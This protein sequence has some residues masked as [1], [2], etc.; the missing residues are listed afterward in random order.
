MAAASIIVRLIGILYRIPLINII[1]DK[2]MGYYSNAFVIYSILLLL[3]SYSLPLAV[4]KMVSA[5]VARGQYKNSVRILRTALA[6]ATLVGGIGAAVTWFGANFFA[7]TFFP[8]PFCVYAIKTLAPTVWIMAYLGVFRGYFQGMGTMIPTAMSQILEQIINA[9]ISVGAAYLLFDYGINSNLVYE[10]TEYSYAFGA[11]GGT[12]GTGAG[13]LAALV[14]MLLLFAVYR[15]VLKKQLRRDRTRKL[16]SYSQIGYVLIMTVVPVILSSVIYNI[17]SVIDSSIFGHCITSMGKND[18]YT[19]LWGIYSGKYHLLTNVPIA[20]ASALSSSLIP[21]LTRAT[22]SGSK[23]Q[24]NDRVS[25]AIRFAMILAIPSAVGLTVLAGPITNLLFSGDNEIAIQMMYLGASAVVFFSL[26]TVTNAILQGTN[27]MRDP[28]R[29]AAIALIIHC[30]LL[31]V[32][33]VGLDLGIYGVVLANILF[34][35][36]MCVFNGVCINKYLEYRQEVKK[37]FL[38]PLLS[39]A[40]MGGAAYGV[41]TGL[42]MVFPHNT[43]CTLVSILVAVAIYFVLLL[44]LRC[45]DEVE[46]HGMPKGAMLVRVAHKLHLL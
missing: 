43:V 24:V 10:N 40:I 31:V 21:A 25:T 44:K 11:A 16:Q 38:L 28:V 23:G 39:S 36:L 34:A 33:L 26:S 20:I 9:V 13:A 2:G 41:Y 30:V 6:F 15:V 4:S 14:F 8:M 7:N 35:V 42:Y 29:N 19:T 3:S 32:M 46:L 12:I 18:E 17:S 37:T 45:V 22:E 27:H 5:K 1:G